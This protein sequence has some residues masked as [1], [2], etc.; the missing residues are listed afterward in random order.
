[1]KYKLSKTDYGNL[2]II[3]TLKFQHNKI[4]IL[5]DIGQQKITM[6][7]QM[8]EFYTYMNMRLRVSKEVKHSERFIGSKTPKGNSSR[9]YINRQNL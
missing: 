1:M 7:R 8:R 9:R 4:C 5:I 3:L 6:C 2:L